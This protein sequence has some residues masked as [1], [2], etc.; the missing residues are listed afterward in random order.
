MLLDPDDLIHG[1]VKLD[2]SRKYGFGLDAMRLWAISRDSDV[3][4]YLDR[5]DLD[6]INQEM[7]MFRGLLRLILGNLNTYDAS[8]TPFEFDKLTFVDKVLTCKLLKFLSDV[9]ESYDNC[10]LREV[11]EHIFR[12]AST[13]LTDYYLPLSR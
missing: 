9:Q 2:G 13:D 6:E 10:N 1:T 12:F 5:Q 7:K 3:N 11:Y 4:F 8:K